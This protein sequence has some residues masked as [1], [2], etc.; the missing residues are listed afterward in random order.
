MRGGNANA[1]V[2]AAGDDFFAGPSNLTA[3]GEAAPG[4]TA[5]IA[6]APGERGGGVEESCFALAATP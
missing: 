1:A 2:F 6:V 3:A 5:G 4:E